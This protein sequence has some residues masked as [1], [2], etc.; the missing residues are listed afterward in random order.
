VDQACRWRGVASRGNFVTVTGAF[1]RKGKLA[2]EPTLSV[3]L[4]TLP[5]ISNGPTGVE[6]LT[7][8]ADEVLFKPKKKG[9]GPKPPMLGIGH[10]L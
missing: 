10:C 6:H 2:I 4:L 9:K 1:K 8:P 5:L 7:I 3:S